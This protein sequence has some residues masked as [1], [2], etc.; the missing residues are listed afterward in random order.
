MALA[1]AGCGGDSTT[2][3]G[4][5]SLL[6]QQQAAEAREAREQQAQAKTEDE[7]VAALPKPEIP[8]GPP[9]QS[10]VVVDKSQGSGEAVGNGDQVRMDYIGYV[11]KTK[12]LF[13]A[14]WEKGEPFS[15]TLGR[16]EAIAGWDQGIVGM[17]VGGERELTIPPQLAYGSQGVYPSIPPNAT[18]VFLV[19][20]LAVN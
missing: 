1:L 7:E 9:P 8:S 5:P 2:T 15:F 18:L 17:K 4:S 13:E 10:L 16:G 19:K 3:S 14:N 20:L 11:Y 6:E 12:K